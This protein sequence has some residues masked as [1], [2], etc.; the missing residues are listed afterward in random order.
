MRVGVV[1]KFIKHTV[2]FSSEKHPE[3]AEHVFAFVKWK[4]VH[5]FCDFFGF[6]LLFA[7]TYLN[8]LGYAVSYLCKGLLAVQH[9][10]SCK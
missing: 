4:K 3:K 7:L 10:Q 2:A 8:H 5:P 6:L 1:Q 9:M